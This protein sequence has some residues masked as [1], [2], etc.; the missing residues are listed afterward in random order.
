MRAR[1]VDT[2]YLEAPSLRR[3]EEFLDLVRASRRLHGAWVKPPSTREEFEA[4]LKTARKRSSRCF[5]I[6]VTD[7]RALAGV[8]NITQIVCGGFQSAYLGFYGFQPTARTGLMTRGLRQVLDLAFGTME[9]HRLEA[10]VQPSN[11]AS[12]GFVKRLGFRR[13]GYS[14]KYLKIRGRWRDHER[15]ALL[16]EDW[17]RSRE[18]GRDG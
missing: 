12:L 11:F 1:H 5:F 13:E 7:G 8:A 10:N 18:N 6:C 3:Q 16:A 9:L 2:V 14:E 17:K 15:W 4:Y